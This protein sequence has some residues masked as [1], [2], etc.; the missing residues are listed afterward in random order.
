MLN[1]PMANA[2]L[3]AQLARHQQRMQMN[4][5]IQQMTAQVA[6]DKAKAAD[7]ASNAIRDYIKG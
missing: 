7:K 4:D 6:V 1:D 5:A 3:A 2:Q